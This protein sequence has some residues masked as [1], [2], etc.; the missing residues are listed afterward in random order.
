MD[1]VVSGKASSSENIADPYT[2]LLYY[3]YEHVVDVDVVCKY[4]IEMCKRLNLMGRI[5][6][7]T[8]GI[9]GTLGGLPEDILAYTQEMDSIQPKDVIPIHWKLSNLLPGINRDGQKFHTLSV[10]STKEVVSMDL[11]ERE[12]AVLLEGWLTDA[13]IVSIILLIY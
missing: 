11:T 6:V 1:F 7:A 5:R 12:K 2:I 10:K 13:S 4:Q 3:Q 9:N 8:E